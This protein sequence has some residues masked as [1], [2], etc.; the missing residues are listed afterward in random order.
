MLVRIRIGDEEQQL[1]WDEWEYRVRAGRVPPTALVHFEA[2]TG[3]GFL[4]AGELEMYRSLRNEAAIAWRGRFTSSP[5]PVLTALLVGVQVRIWWAAR[6]PE[7]EEVLV[8]RFTNW[9]SPT[10][11]DGEFWRLITMGLLHTETFHLILNMLWLAYTG[12]NLERA[13][14]RANLFTLYFASVLG[15]SLASMFGTPDTTSLGASGGVFGL[16][17][18]SVVFGFTRPELLPERGRRLFGVAMAPYLLVMFASGLAN[19]GTDNW[20]HLGGLVTGGLLVLALDPDTLQRRTRWNLWVQLSVG[21]VAAAVL[22][23]LALFGPRIHPL[24]DAERIAARQHPGGDGAPPVHITLDYRVPLG[25]KPGASAARDLGFTSRVGSRVWAVSETRHEGPVEVE[26]LAGSWLEA[27]QRSWPDARPGELESTRIAGMAGWRRIVTFDQGRLIEWKC[28]TRGVWSLEVVWQVDADRIDRLATLRDRLLERVVWNEPASLF[29][30]RAAAAR[31]PYSTRRQADLARELTLVG[32]V[33]G[34]METWTSLLADRPDD[35]SLW[36]GVLETTRWYPDPTAP[37]TAL[38]EDA[39]RLHPEPRVVGEVIGSLEAHGRSVE[40]VGLAEIAWQRWPGDR[41]LARGRMA[42]DLPIGLDAEHHRPWYLT[43]DPL[44]WELRD[45]EWGG[46]PTLELEAALVRGRAFQEMREGLV[47]QAL[48]RLD[49]G[50]LAVIDTLLIL[51]H[52]APPEDRT[53][54]VVELGVGLEVLASGGQV[55]WMPEALQRG[56]G[57]RLHADPAGRLMERI[58]SGG[59][60]PDGGSWCP[61]D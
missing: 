5:P 20:S 60:C 10:L 1:T 32:D 38:W 30:A 46:P 6:L 44:T 12:W 35:V 45:E 36:L 54:A 7:V 56:I 51:Q 53:A 39:L 49:A 47:E 19:S 16:V 2:V 8:Q 48:H 43:H 50:D 26:A 29:R 22:A 27:V 15:G 42:H 17:A 13:L 24:V 37:P 25:W 41:V 18:A 14:G 11:E 52:A 3:E 31:S 4:P 59:P 33:A 61:G 9:T 21:A 58:R 57:E 55:P 28:A 40:A 34:A 23:G